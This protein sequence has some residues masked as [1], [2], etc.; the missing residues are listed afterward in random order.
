MTYLLRRWCF[1]AILLFV[2][3]PPGASRATELQE[4]SQQQTV[5]SDSPREAMV[6]FLG[7]MKAFTASGFVDEDA[8]GRATSTFTATSGGVERDVNNLA[9]DLY[10]VLNKTALIDLD[11]FPSAGDPAL[12]SGAW[13]WAKRSPFEDVTVTLTFESLSVNGIK[14]WSLSA[15]TLDAVTAWMVSL[16]QH[17]PVAEYAEGLPV[18]EKLRWQLRNDLP[19]S[20]RGRLFLLETWQW[21]GLLLLIIVGVIADRVIT[22]I[23]S[24]LAQRAAGRVSL[25]REAVVNFQRPFG[26]LIVA[27]TFLQLLPVLGLQPAQHRIL[28]F[29]AS[30]VIAVAGVWT[31]YRIV[32][33]VC[34][35][36]KRKAEFSDNKFD[37]MLVPLLERTLKILVTVAGLVYLASQLSEDLYGIVAGLSIGSLA[38]GFAAKDSI[39]NLFGTFTVLLDKPFELGDWIT[40]GSIDGSVERVGFRSTRVRTFYDS[41]ITVPNSHFIGNEVDNHGSRTYRRYTTTL[42]LTY[43]TPP[44]KIEAFCEGV[45]ELIRRHPY[46]RKDSFHVY[47]KDFGAN[48]IDVMLYCFVKTPDWGT[49]LRERG[50]LILDILRLAES[51]GVEF[52]FPTRTVHM[53]GPQDIPGHDDAPPTVDEALSR[54]RDVAER[55]TPDGEVP[56]PVTYS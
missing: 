36:L 15:D 34:A 31:A 25:D 7:G 40:V 29:A 41:L 5:S 17:P 43:D 21:I 10:G 35:Y 50:R 56:P 4:A 3:A 18:F 19:S 23:I 39:E 1:A 30:F 2:C 45:R 51:L 26:L 11:E 13:S 14:S 55:L 37:D 48:S 52:A 8:L 42:G 49:E 47:V 33:V 6:E 46:T 44:S 53:M 54:G 24:K 28:A 9:L 38:V 22:A 32:D 27:L 16:A 12:E 20:L